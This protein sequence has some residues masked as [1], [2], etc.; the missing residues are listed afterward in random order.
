[1]DWIL[2]GGVVGL[3]L[4]VSLVAGFAVGRNGEPPPGG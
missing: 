1:M 3:M 2:I 4:L